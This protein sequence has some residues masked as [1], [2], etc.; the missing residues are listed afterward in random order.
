MNPPRVAFVTSGLGTGGAEHM[1]VKL[2]EVAAGTPCSIMV[3]SLLD[4]GNFAARIEASGVELICCQLKRPRGLLGLWNA[5]RRLRT[6][7]PTVIQG[8]M[9]HG[10]LLASLF[11]W[12]LPGRP[13]VFWSIRQTLYSLSSESSRLRLVI[14]ALALISR[15][16]HCVIYNSSLSLR[17]HQQIG[18]VSQRDLM[19][20]NGFDLD[21]YRPDPTRR[22]RL[23]AH[24]GI[25]DDVPLVGIVARVHP[26]KDHANFIAAAIL[27][28]AKIPTMRFLFAGTGT[29]GKEMRTALEAAG[30]GERTFCLGR[31]DDTDTLYPALDLLVLSSAWGEGWPNVLGEAMACGVPCVT[32]DIGESRLIVGETGC[33]VPAGNP[34]ALASACQ[35]LLGWPAAAL[36]S[37]GMQARARV[38]D[39]FDIKAV[40]RLYF[41]AWA[42]RT[43]RKEEL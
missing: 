3:V 19:I 37:L 35:G 38:T 25:A 42:N 4:S 15:R 5:Y 30:L 31:I 24:L 34:E 2:I 39:E 27:L 33:I 8:W 26:M 41:E 9:Y 43:S 13:A 32:T 16:V 6:F 7:Q 11:G 40:Y 36:R 20:P 29:D 1:L 14:R 10:N 18:I 23:R 22:G 12:A 28:S 21:R 17:Q